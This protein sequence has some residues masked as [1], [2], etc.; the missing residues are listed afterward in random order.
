MQHA[1]TVLQMRICMCLSTL[2]AALL[3]RP[4]PGS[5]AASKCPGS[6][7]GTAPGTH[8]QDLVMVGYPWLN[9]ER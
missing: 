2:V 3:L 4:L 9:Q 7:S 6:L 5:T 1:V 8:W